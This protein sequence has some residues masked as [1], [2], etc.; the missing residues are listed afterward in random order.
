V[1]LLKED[2]SLTEHRQL[3]QEDAFQCIVFADGGPS[4]KVPLTNEHG[5]Y[6]T[7]GTR[8]GAISINTQF[9]CITLSIHINKQFNNYAMTVTVAG[10]PSSFGNQAAA[11]LQ[12]SRRAKRSSTTFSPS[13][14]PAKPMVAFWLRPRG[15][16]EQLGSLCLRTHNARQV[17]LNAMCS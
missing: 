10:F 14:F 17:I 15:L 1:E 6:W 13:R 16:L 12:P 11:Q 4:L 2:Y 3:V 9:C 5:T 7:H 8:E